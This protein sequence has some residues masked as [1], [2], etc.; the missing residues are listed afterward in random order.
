MRIFNL[1]RGQGK[2]MRMLY[3]S[4]FNDIP[5]LCSTEQQKNYLINMAKQYGINIPTPLTI[6][7]LINT[8]STDKHHNNDVVVDDMEY[9]LKEL[10]KAEYGLN[11]IGATITRDK[12]TEIK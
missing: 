10:L 1:A 12:D 3:A 8:V 11:M 9:V 5:I 6:Y 2:T 4:E 7:K